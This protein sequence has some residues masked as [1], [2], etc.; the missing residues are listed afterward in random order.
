MGMGHE[1]THDTLPG[2]V[3]EGHSEQNQRGLYK[4]WAELMAGKSWDE[5]ANRK[6]K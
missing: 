5:L 3:S 6:A 1:S 4:R 2:L